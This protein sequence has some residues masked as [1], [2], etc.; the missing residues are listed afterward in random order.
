MADKIGLY[1]ALFDALKGSGGGGAVDDVQID[2]TSIV[3]GNGVANV[4]AATNGSYGV[5]KPT[6]TYGVSIV[7]GSLGL[8]LASDTEIKSGASVYHPLQPGRQHNSAFYGLAKAAGDSTQSASANAV[9]TY[10]EDAKSAISSMLSAPE[11]VSGTTPTITAKAGVQYI[12]GEVSTID[13]TPSATGVCDVVF[14]SGSTPAVLTVPNT[15]KFPSW[16]DPTSLD[17]NTTYEINVLNG[18]LGAV[19]AWA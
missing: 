17:A 8:T 5:V 9:G 7:N 15:V 3:D 1:L 6:A 18:T 16:F 19:M 4:P 11:T 14:T 2:G 10:T 13:F 12:C